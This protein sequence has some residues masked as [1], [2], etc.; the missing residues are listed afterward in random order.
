[1]QDYEEEVMEIFKRLSSENQANLLMCT[2]LAYVAECSIKKTLEDLPR[3][4][5]RD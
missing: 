1:M 4:G 3:C 5:E 2:R